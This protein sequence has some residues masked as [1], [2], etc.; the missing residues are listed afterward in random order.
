MKKFGRIYYCIIALV[1]FGIC[2]FATVDTGSNYR[3]SFIILSFGM[4][5]EKLLDAFSPRRFLGE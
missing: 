1:W 2:V 3:I 4:G 5:I